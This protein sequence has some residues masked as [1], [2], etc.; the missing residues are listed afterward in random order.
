MG[1]LDRALAEQF[2]FHALLQASLFL[3]G[4]YERDPSRQHLDGQRFIVGLVAADNVL[5]G[6]PEAVAAA[7]IKAMEALLIGG[8]LQKQVARPALE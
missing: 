4:L 3:G 1:D 6:M 8:H 2:H 7:Q 5:R